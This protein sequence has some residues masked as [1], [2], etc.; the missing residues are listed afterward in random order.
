MAEQNAAETR[1]GSHQ[2]QMAFPPQR[3]ANRLGNLGPGSEKPAK[4]SAACGSSDFEAMQSEM[5][6]GIG[7][8][9]RV[10]NG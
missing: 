5:A 2:L 4:R 8:C 10:K 6:G 3:Q 1:I 7:G 9:E